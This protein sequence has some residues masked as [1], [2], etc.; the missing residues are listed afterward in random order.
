MLALAATLL[1]PGG[2]LTYVVCSLLPAEGEARVSA[3]LATTAEFAPAAVC[4]PG[5]DPYATAVVL[6]PKTQGCDGFFIARLQRV[7]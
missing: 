3:F 2:V 7:C 1:R 4:I 5:A 6:S